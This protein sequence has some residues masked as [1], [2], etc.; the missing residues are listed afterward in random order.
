[1][2]LTDTFKKFFDQAETGGLE[3]ASYPA[4]YNDLI[5]DVGFGFGVPTHIPWIAFLAHGQTVRNGIFPVFYFF[6]K[7][8]YVILAYGISEENIP[9]KSWGAPLKV[10]TVKQCFK[11]KNKIP[12]KYHK[13]Y[14]FATYT[15]LK[16]LDYEQ[17]ETDLQKLIQHYK[18]RFP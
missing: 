14:V 3:T 11:T 5:M 6:K 18:T 2:K 7:L 4:A 15:T 13:S 16:D 8:H 17:M 9:V 10:Q 1:M 12:Q